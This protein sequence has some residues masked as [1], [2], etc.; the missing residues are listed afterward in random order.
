MPAT[1]LRE[2]PFRQATIDALPNGERPSA[3]HLYWPQLDLDLSVR[4][5]RQPA[6]FPLMSRRPASPTDPM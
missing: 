2:G 6:D 4:S 1:V 3:N 5:I